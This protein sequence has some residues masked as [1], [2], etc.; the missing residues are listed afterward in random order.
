MCVTP[1]GWLK[2]IF[3]CDITWIYVPMLF[4][5]YKYNKYQKNGYRKIGERFENRCSYT[6]VQS[7]NI[8]ITLKEKLVWNQFQLMDKRGGFWEAMEMF[9]MEDSPRNYFKM[10]YMKCHCKQRNIFFL[11]VAVLVSVMRLTKQLLSLWLTS[12]EHTLDTSEICICSGEDGGNVRLMFSLWL[13]LAIGKHCSL[14]DLRL[15]CSNTI[16]LIHLCL[17]FIHIQMYPEEEGHVF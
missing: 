14:Q 6:T 7:I 11:A 3:T 10:K 17:S 12:T 9:N 4:L 2:K 1:Y 5:L 16:N 8:G 15:T 13:W